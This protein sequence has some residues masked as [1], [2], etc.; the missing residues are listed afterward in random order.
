M[1]DQPP[2]GR[3]AG[4]IRAAQG[5]T[6]TNLLILA[7]LAVVVVPVYVVYRALGD[8]ALLDRLMSTYE[9]ID[10]HAGCAVRHVQERGGPDLWGISSGFAFQGAERYYVN[11]I[12]ERAPSPD[13]VAAHCAVLKLIADSMLGHGDVQRGPVPGAATD[14]GEHYRDLPAAEEEK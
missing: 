6:L 7:G 1:T 9:V 11:V 4:W 14:G 3:V 2:D 5:L 10:S 13:E 12:L 8:E